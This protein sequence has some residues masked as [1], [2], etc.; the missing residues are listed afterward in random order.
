[1]SSP[2]ELV[3][4]DHCFHA[5][6]FGFSEDAGVS[7]AIFSLDAMDLPAALLVVP[8]QTLEVLSIGHP[9]FISIEEHRNK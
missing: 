8:L 5:D 1:M 3:H 4:E 6:D 2:A 9:G 7:A